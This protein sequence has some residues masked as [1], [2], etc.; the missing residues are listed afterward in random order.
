MYW[1]RLNISP[2]TYSGSLGLHTPLA[3]PPIRTLVLQ[4]IHPSPESCFW[5]YDVIYDYMHRKLIT[6]MEKKK[7]HHLCLRI[8][9]H[10]AGRLD[11]DS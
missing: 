9:A 8:F 2:C 6:E 5:N 3:A 10:T 4:S 7:K 11:Y 1:V